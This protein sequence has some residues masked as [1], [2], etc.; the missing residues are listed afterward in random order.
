MNNLTLVIPAKQEAESLPHVLQEVKELNLNCKIKVCLSALDEETVN[1]IK[2]FDIEIYYQ[3]E[4]GY[5]A[6]LIE[7]INSVKTE[8]FCIMNADGSTDPNELMQMYEKI[9]NEKIDF[10]F[11]SRY[12]KNAGSDD[13]TIIT[14][15]GNFGF[16][17][18]GKL[19]FRL[20]I[21]DILYTYVLGRTEKFKKINFNQ[22]DFS[23][24][25]ELPIKCHKK[26]LIIKDIN[27][28][29]RARIGGVKKVNALKDGFLLL[30]QMIKL[31]FKSND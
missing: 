28:Y 31:Y 8:F 26:K 13:D 2:E 19:F 20:P 5:G 1:A 18:I 11:A 7:G 3:N 17:L 29:E 30:L 4:M 27:S 12:L 14:S 6:A 16:S 15:I 24:C 21:S 23:F 9:N 25:V 10:L 22:K